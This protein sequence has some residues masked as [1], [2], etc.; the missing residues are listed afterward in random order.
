MWLPLSECVV[1]V[2]P[3]KR[4]CTWWTPATLNADPVL[5]SAHKIGMPNDW[6]KLHSLLLRIRRDVV[7]PS[8]TGNIPTPIDGFDSCVFLAPPIPGATVGIAID[9]ASHPN[10]AFGHPETVATGIPIDM[11]EALPVLVREDQRATYAVNLVPILPALL[12]YYKSL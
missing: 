10:F 7:L 1:G 11:I 8:F 9:L 4:N 12:S 2:L 3:G 6:V 5:P